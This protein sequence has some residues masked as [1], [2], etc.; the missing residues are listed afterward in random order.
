MPTTGLPGNSRTPP[1][2]P[3]RETIWFAN[4]PGYRIGILPGEGVVIEVQDYH[5]GY[6]VLDPDDLKGM[7]R[8]LAS[9]RPP[10]DRLPAVAAG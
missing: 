9:E 10:S 5:A 1:D 3:P 7:L 4:V 2:R 6:L 8:A